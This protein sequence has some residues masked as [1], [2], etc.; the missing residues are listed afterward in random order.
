MDKVYFRVHKKLRVLKTKIF[1]LDILESMVKA[2]QKGSLH[3][4]RELCT[5]SYLFS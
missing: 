2:K 5:Y 4:Y 3:F 1:I